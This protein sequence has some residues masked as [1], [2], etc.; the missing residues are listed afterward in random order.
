VRAGPL[1]GGGELVIAPGAA[2]V[3]LRSRRG[4]PTQLVVR[5]GRRGAHRL[6]PSTLRLGD[7]FGISGRELRSSATDVLVLPRIEPLSRRLLA[8]LVGVGREQR[9]RSLHAA[10]AEA[11]GLG[12][13]RPGAPATRIHWPSVARTGTLL[14]RRLTGESE[15]LPLVVLDARAPASDEALDAA[16]RAAGSLAVALAGLGGC[17][18]LLP[19]EQRAHLLDAQLGPWP[20][21]H[22]RLA[23]V[24]A[25]GL[26]AGAVLER[27]PIVRWVTAYAQPEPRARRGSAALLLVTPFAIPGRRVLLEVAGCAVQPLGTARRAA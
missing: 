22:A 11:D 16:V 24:A 23:L 5:A 18:L 8:P 9:L 10:D 25:G 1:A 19:G 21:L 26:L 13:Y 20:A 14:E 27:A 17:M 3:T 15:R 7:P 2:P 4:A 12:P 6:G